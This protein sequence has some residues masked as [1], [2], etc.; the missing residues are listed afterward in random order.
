[1]TAGTYTCKDYR[2]EMMLLGLK[3]RLHS[4]DLPEGERRIIKRQIEEIE[5]KMRMD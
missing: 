5:K 2:E 3:K 4:V 1:M